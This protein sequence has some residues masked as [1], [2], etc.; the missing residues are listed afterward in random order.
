M[1]EEEEV[2][3]GPKEVGLRYKVQSH[4]AAKV[5]KRWQSEEE[6]KGWARQY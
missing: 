2:E 5:K 6:Q 4:N 3:R 1:G